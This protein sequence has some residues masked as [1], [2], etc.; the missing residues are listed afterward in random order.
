MVV[1]TL[2]MQ[3]KEKLFTKYQKNIYNTKLWKYFKLW[4]QLTDTRGTNGNFT[5]GYILLYI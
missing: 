1:T 2:Y 5:E 4:K 3:N